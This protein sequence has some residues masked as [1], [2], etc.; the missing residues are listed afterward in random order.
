MIGLADWLCKRAARGPERPALSFDDVTWCYAELQDRVER[1]SAVLAGGGVTP[2]D[3]VG[4][5]GFNHPLFLVALFATARLGAIF[6]PLNFRLAAPEIE[7]IV[8]DASIH[9][10]LAGAEH[11]DTIAA[12]RP[13]LQCRRYL[14]VDAPADGWEAARDLMATAAAQPAAA[15][16]A[17]AVAAIIYTSGTTGTPKGAMLTHANFWANNLNANLVFDLVASDVALNSAPLFHVGGLCVV[18]L[19]TLLAGGHLV[20]QESFEPRQFMQAIERH[21]VT[22][23]FAVPSMLLFA[24]QHAAFDSADLS[25]LRL[26]AVG[27]G[28]VPEPLLRLYNGR[29]IPVHQGYGMTETTVIVTFLSPERA[30]EKLGS[31]GNAAIL[32]EFMLKDI[33]GQPILQPHEKGEVCV[34]GSNVMKGYW[35]RPEAT[36]A[37]FDEE[38]WFHTGDIGH[39]DADGYLYLCDRLK[40]MI[41]SGGENV[42]PAEVE[43]ALCDHPALAEIAIVG[44][45]DARWGERVVAAVVPNPG[46]AIT[47][48]ELQAYGS[49]RLARY[50]LPRELRLME[51]LPRNPAGKVLKNKLRQAEPAPGNH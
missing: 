11:I 34:R 32:T 16:A 25:S 39:M 13:A 9:T 12:L 27:G 7:F 31:C 28:P 33:Q 4:Y 19:P 41:I 14:A 21:R 38:G 10:L 36:A 26:I 47:L 23:S 8:G 29:G 2:G 3:R 22:V 45:L 5:L 6:V 48:D 42:Y 44:A 17:D 30:I 35:Q 24:S 37:V 20:L 50:K 46:M 43:S 40:D 1:L 51:S 49:E 15:V 18:S